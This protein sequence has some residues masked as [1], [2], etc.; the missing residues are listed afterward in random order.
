LTQIETSVSLAVHPLLGDECSRSFREHGHWTGDT[1][2]DAFLSHDA[3]GADRPAVVGPDPLTRAQLIDRARRLAGHLRGVGVE[4]GDVVLAVLAYDTAAVVTTLAASLLGVKLLGISRDLTAG[5]ILGLHAAAGPTAVILDRTGQQPDDRT[6]LDRVA[7]GTGTGRYL[8]ADDEDLPPGAARLADVWSSAPCYEGNDS[9]ASSCSV[10]IP[11]GGTTGEPKLVQQHDDSLVYSS[12]QSIRCAEI[13]EDDVYLGVGPFGHIMTY[14]ATYIALVSGAAL[15]P[16]AGWR[17]GSD[18]AEL[19]GATGATVSMMTSTHAYDLLQLD[20]E[21]GAQLA[22]L[23]RIMSAGKP[24]EF[25]TDLEA[26]Y[27]LRMLRLYGLS[28]VGTHVHVSLGDADA[29]T[30]DGRPMPG[31]EAR[32][33]DPETGAV[34]GAGIAGEYQVRG[35]SMCLGYFDGDAATIDSLTDDGFWR[36]GDL[37]TIDERGFVQ[38]CGRI[39][40]SIRRG[41]ITIH[42]EE[43]ETLL[44]AH[45]DIVEA[46]LVGSP[47]R[48]LGQ[49]VNVVAVLGSGTTLDISDVRDHLLANGVPRKELPDRLIEVESIPRTDLGRLSK[50]HLV[51]QLEAAA[52]LH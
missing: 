14:F 8:V 52:R 20:V 18:A 51:A 36:T 43:I 9:D 10:L 34:V 50:R 39:K 15:A 19:V 32:I 37:A 46:C 27:G 24:D 26:R 23:T 41:G 29:E 6:A 3:T 44:F 12:R 48:R 47:D 35:P 31:T 2:A 1:V 17:R 33:V 13:T 45:P 4:R 38:I 40:E 5:R 22:P 21:Q 16:C 28:E 49:I 25:F 7:S 30:A 42:P 11:T